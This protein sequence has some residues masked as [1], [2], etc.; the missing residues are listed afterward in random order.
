MSR[1]SSNSMVKQAVSEECTSRWPLIGD[2]VQPL[3]GKEVISNN[4]AWQLAV[5]EIATVA[6]V[7][8][9]GDFLLLNAEGQQSK[10]KYRKDFC[11]A[12]AQTSTTGLERR[13][14][15]GKACALTPSLQLQGSTSKCP[16]TTTDDD[17]YDVNSE[18]YKTTCILSASPPQPVTAT[19][20]S[21]SVP[22]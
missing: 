7:D 19:M 13:W 5:G 10:W 1:L 21:K 9:D 4:G 11:Y 14:I 16:L 22:A 17:T 12:K 8:K 3:N 2:K 20:A 6:E 18:S 15:S